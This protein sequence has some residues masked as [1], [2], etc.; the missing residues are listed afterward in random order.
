MNFFELINSRHSIRSFQ[1]Q[2]IEEKKIQNILEAAN[3][4]PSAGNLQAYEIFLVMNQNKRDLLARAAWMQDFISSAPVALVFCTHAKRAEAK[5]GKRGVQL[6]ALQDATIA[7]TYAMLA[8]SALGL[9]SVW[10]GAFNDDAVKSTIEAPEGVYPVAILPIGYAAEEPIPSS[11]RELGSLVH[12][13][14]AR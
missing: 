14:E 10:V 2:E 9:A 13:V 3:Q 5:Y 4:A 7:C 11:R 12:R 1:R 6:Y 8:A